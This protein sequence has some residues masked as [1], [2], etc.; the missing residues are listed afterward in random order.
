M[1]IEK[2][3]LFVVACSLLV[4]WPTLVLSGFSPSTILWYLA[5][6]GVGL[7]ILILVI[8]ILICLLPADE[9]DE[10]SILIFVPAILILI[11]PTIVIFLVLW[12]FNLFPDHSAILAGL[13][14]VWEFIIDYI[15][16]IFFFGYP[17]WSVVSVV[18]RK[19]RRKHHK[20]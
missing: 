2:V 14:R 15:V 18:S 8:V 6:G 13:S 7:I 17:I 5:W 1:D 10:L 11:V 16:L 3:L 20:H 4:I 12:I 9:E 19:L